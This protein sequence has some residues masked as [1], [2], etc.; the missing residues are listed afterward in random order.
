MSLAYL[1]NG[2]TANEM[3]TAA[4]GNTTARAIHNI[5]DAFNQSRHIAKP[6]CAIC[7]SEQGILAAH[8]TKSMSDTAALAPVL[9]Q[10]HNPQDIMQAILLRKIQNHID[11]LVATPVIDN[12]DFIAAET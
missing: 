10:R 4:D 7:I 8:M 12:D 6:R 5:F 1:D 2:F 3:G 9:S 11:R